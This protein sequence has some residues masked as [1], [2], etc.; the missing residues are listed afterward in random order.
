LFASS[1]RTKFDDR[2]V[3]DTQSGV[4]GR[5]VIG[6]TVFA[7]VLQHEDRD[8]GPTLTLRTN[9]L[10]T[11]CLR[12]PSCFLIELRPWFTTLQRNGGL[13]FLNGRQFSPVVASEQDEAHRFRRRVSSIV[14]MTV[15]LFGS[16]CLLS[17][18]SIQRYVAS[19]FSK[20]YEALTGDE[21]A[22]PSTAVPPAPRRPFKQASADASD[23][24]GENGRQLLAPGSKLP[25]DAS[26]CS[27]IR[28][29]SRQRQHRDD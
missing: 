20:P 16:I 1:D 26:R 15:T 4:D 21:T 27:V 29:P 2:V 10:R 25:A 5:K 13:D 22:Y 24:H 8:V 12:R 9:P 7:K 23:L 6:R 17:V 3:D 14:T 11:T 18:S 28:W 19:R